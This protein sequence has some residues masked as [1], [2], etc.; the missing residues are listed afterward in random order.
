MPIKLSPSLLAADF[1]RLAE[2]V[3]I[4]ENAGAEYLHID[5]MDGLFVP[6]ITLGPCVISAIRPHTRL[7]FDVHLMICEPI[8]YLA[9][10]AKAGADIIT[11]HYEACEDPAQTLREIRKLGVRAGLSIKPSTD[12]ALIS[13]LLPLCDLI[14]VMSVEPGFGGQKYIEGSDERAARIRDMLASA[15]LSCEIEMDGG[16]TPALTAKA[17]RAGVNVI[18][19]GS[20]FF[21]AADPG[22]AA[23]DFRAA[24]LLA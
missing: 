11:V 7:I 2:Q 4:A 16:L 23:Q 10:F 14:L 6:N 8:R 15:G 5:V 19:A 9:E 13:D 22:K 12:P 20:A 3:S 21:G 18:V 1:S 17:V 24:A